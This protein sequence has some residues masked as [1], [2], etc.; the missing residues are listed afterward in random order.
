MAED[1]FAAYDAKDW[2]RACDLLSPKAKKQIAQAAVFV[3]ADPG[4][5]PKTLEKA[6]AAS[7]QSKS[8]LALK[9]VRITGDTAIAP[10]G[11][12]EDGKPTDLSFERVDG[13]WYAG[14]DPEERTG[15]DE[16]P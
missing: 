11:S 13:R 6:V 9:T 14:P 5:C 3:G 2:D 12:I 15:S 10:D 7:R 1:F 8:T 4:D 16:T